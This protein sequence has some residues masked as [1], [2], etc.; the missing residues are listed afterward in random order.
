M[1]AEEMTGGF[2]ATEDGGF[3]HEAMARVVAASEP[4]LGLGIDDL[5][6]AS[7]TRVRRRRWSAAVGGVAVLAAMGVGAAGF[8]AHGSA[9][10]LAATGTPQ[11]RAAANDK[12]EYQAAVKLVRDLDPHG[13]HI[14]LLNPLD[15]GTNVMTCFAQGN[16]F[17]YL[18][19]ARWLAKNPGQWVPS[20]A[21]HVDIELL[22]RDSRPGGP[23]PPPLSGKPG[24]GPVTKTT[25]ADGSVV[26]S[27]QSVLNTPGEEAISVWRTLPDGRSLEVDVSNAEVTEGKSVPLEPFP[28]TEQQVVEAVGDLKLKLPF[29]Y[30]YE[31][32]DHC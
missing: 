9:P 20:Q 7:R 14:A 29:A 16:S 30:G 10:D 27:A 6:R 13:T 24:W 18:G 19:S 1:A 17:V 21:P 11:Q 28:L 8:A 32:R 3:A 5:V 2:E 12:L 26:E 23:P 31:P 4:T 25:L 15:A 22:F